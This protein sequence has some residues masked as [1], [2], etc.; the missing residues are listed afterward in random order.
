MGQGFFGLVLHG[1]LPYVRHPE[2]ERSLQEHWFFDAISET[3][4]PLLLMLNRLRDEGVPFRIT[5]SLSPTLCTMF[6][7]DLLQTRYVDHLHRLIDLGE[8]EIRRNEGNPVLE[9]L[10]RMYR[11]NYV[12]NLHEFIDVYRFNILKGYKQLEKEGYLDIITTSAT[13]SFL[14]LYQ[15]FP[16]SIEAQIQT[17][18]I[19]HGRVLGNDPKG[20]WIPECGYFPGMEKYLKAYGIRY[21]FTAAH[22]ILLADRKPRY[23]V[24]APLECPN[25]VYTFGWDLPSAQAVWS[26]D[27]GYPGDFSYRDFYRDIGCE[28]PLD[29][30]GSLV[31]RQ[32]IRVKTGYKYY[33]RTGKTGEKQPY[34]IREAERR[35]Q[36]H[37]ENFI[38]NRQKQIC[39]VSQLMDRPP[40]ILVPF[41][42][43]LFGHWW[44]EGLQWLERVIRMIGAK[45]SGMSMLTPTD[46]LGLYPQNQ[47]GV[48]SFSSWGNKGYA[49]VWL[50]SSNDWIYPHIHK[51]VERM[52]ELVERFP[53]ESG[54]KE[55]VLNQA[56]REV[57]LSQASDWPFIMKA[58]PAA[59]Y[60]AERVKE[61]LYN[62]N[63]IY[64]NLCRNTVNTEWLT[65]LERDHNIFPDIDYRVFGKKEDRT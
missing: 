46:Y 48:P 13:H 10:A 24:Y 60:A 41:D 57:L 36:E 45:D 1:H 31:F 16:E 52:A 63:Q 25:G 40:Y 56:A 65:R 37:A 28:L 7:D 18:V 50:D 8:K 53:A 42:A 43:E 19:S 59:S 22:G 51:A 26:A 61:H 2:E 11:D 4:L 62:F 21:F 32:E 39:K 17:A 12:Q 54:L 35:A 15:A 44:F 64:D 5:L 47:K 27:K 6:L 3:Y 30:L 23:G 38:Y 49:E 14:P 33:A 29:Y 9:S 58:G 34:D 20:M 55:R